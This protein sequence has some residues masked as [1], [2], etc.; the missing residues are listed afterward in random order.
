M[1]L[2]VYEQT[3]RSARGSGRA[4]PAIERYYRVLDDAA[5]R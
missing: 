1:I 4:V 5:A 3:R 2:G